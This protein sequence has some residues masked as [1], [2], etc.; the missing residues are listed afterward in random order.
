MNL[1][2]KICQLEWSL[3]ALSH[4]REEKDAISSVSMALLLKWKK[5]T[6]GLASFQGSLLTF[7]CNCRGGTCSF[8]NPK[9]SC[10]PDHS[11]YCKV[12]DAT[13][14]AHPKARVKCAQENV[15]VPVLSSFVSAKTDQFCW[16]ECEDGF[17][18]EGDNRYAWLNYGN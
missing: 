9:A 12:P 14:D 13:L 18:W 17:V 8:I 11:K 3:F 10:G 16:L 4:F 6:E 2:K 7:R 5:L 1:R 15:A